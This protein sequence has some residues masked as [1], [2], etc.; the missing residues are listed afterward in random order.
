MNHPQM[1]VFHRPVQAR[2]GLGPLLSALILLCQ[3]SPS[4]SRRPQRRGK[5]RLRGGAVPEPGLCEAAGLE[6][7]SGLGS[8]GSRGHLCCQDP[9]LIPHRSP[10]PLAKPT[11][12]SLPDPSRWSYLLLALW[13]WLASGRRPWEEA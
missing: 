10:P 13:T 4:R 6:G 2:A 7:R 9:F 12:L 1:V 8:S 3:N 5:P 11:L